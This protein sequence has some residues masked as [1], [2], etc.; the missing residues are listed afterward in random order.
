LALGGAGLCWMTRAPALGRTAGWAAAGHVAAAWLLAV[1]ALCSGRRGFLAFLIVLLLW[2]A[3]DAVRSRFPRA[4][5]AGLIAILA[6]A[7]AVALLFIA[8]GQIGL[9]NDRVIMARAA[10]EAAAGHPWFGQGDAGTLRITLDPGRFAGYSHWFGVNIGHTHDEALELLLSAGA[11]GLAVVVA[12]AAWL[13]RRVAAIADRRRRRVL[14]ILLIGMAIPALSD[15]TW[16]RP[17]AACAFGAG[18]GIMLKAI[19][20][21]GGPASA[22]VPRLAAT[23]ASW[24]AV[25]AAT[26]SAV[27]AAA[28]ALFMAPAAAVGEG[29]LVAGDL[30]VLIE[31]SCDFGTIV[32]C[33][34]AQL[35]AAQAA[36]DAAL[37][38]ATV[39]AVDT[40]VGPASW[41]PERY[42][43]MVALSRSPEELAE[44]C[45]AGLAIYPFEAG[46]YE[47]LE[48]SRSSHPA[49]RARIPPRIAARLQ[50]YFSPLPAEPAFMAGAAATIDD[51]AD[52]YAVLSGRTLSGTPSPAHVDQVERLVVRYRRM[53]CMAALAFRSAVLCPE[54]MARDLLARLPAWRCTPIDATALAAI[55]AY[56]FTPPQ[57]AR[58]ARFLAIMYPAQSAQAAALI[59]AGAGAGAASTMEHASS[60]WCVWDFLQRHPGAAAAP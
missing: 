31:R 9:H 50:S 10:L 48:R 25:G 30:R 37:A 16:S 34:N 43:I 41:G 17:F 33:G 52:Q 12:L 38:R 29:P 51:A 26:A 42:T 49:L 1:V 15:P 53:P 8:D 2:F 24:L 5:R 28:L 20:A 44:E 47:A 45:V 11:V 58:V 46:L 35:R 39:D 22:G 13:V 56:P 21:E 7:A 60:A 54:L 55:L 6:A 23:A 36:Q 32:R 14:S 59:R 18:L 3:Y 4:G 40:A 27:A 57:A 19:A